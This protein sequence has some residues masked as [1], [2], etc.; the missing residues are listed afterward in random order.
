MRGAC[1]GS[2]CQRIETS[3]CI[4]ICSLESASMASTFTPRS[5]H[6]SSRVENRSVDAHGGTKRIPG[7]SGV[8]LTFPKAC[9]TPTSPGLITAV[10]SASTTRAAMTTR[11]RE[12]TRRIIPTG[13]APSD[14][15]A[16]AAM[17]T[18]NAARRRM[19]AKTSVPMESP[20]TRYG[21]GEGRDQVKRFG[22]A[23]PLPN[24]GPRGATDQLL[25]DRLRA[26]QLALVLELELAGDRRERRVHVRH[27][28]HHGLFLGQRG[29]ALGVGDHVLEDA[30]RQALRHA[31]ALIDALVGPC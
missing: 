10:V 31:A 2:I 16:E 6:C 5:G 18:K 4:P 26:L 3:T 17:R 30:D 9:C 13:R 25:G 12:V 23:P 21:V 24:D 28:R 29:A 27:P 14:L 1:V 15:M 22:P 19:P 20:G 11:L 8:W 7:S